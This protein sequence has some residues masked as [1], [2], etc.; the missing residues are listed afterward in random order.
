[1]SVRRAVYRH[2]RI[3]LAGFVLALCIGGLAAWF[4]VRPI[5]HSEEMTRRLAGQ[6]SNSKAQLEAA[7][8]EHR[9]L[10]ESI[11]AGRAELAELAISLDDSDQLAS[12]QAAVGEV[13]AGAGVRLEQFTVGTVQPGELVDVLPFR[14]N[15]VGQAS[16]V[17]GAMHALRTR[18]PDLAISSFQISQGGRGEAGSVA[19]GFDIAWYIASEGAPES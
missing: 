7:Q 5:M 9:S 17:I 13:F 11:E 3:D 10:L 14:V 1:M 15:G 12:R 18:F 6:L 16:S 19:F 8:S 4:G 2:P